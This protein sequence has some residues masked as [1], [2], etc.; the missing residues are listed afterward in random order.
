MII[1]FASVNDAPEILSIYRPYVLNTPVTFEIDAPSENEMARR[2]VSIGKTYP[3]LV[4]SNGRDIVGYAYAT[5]FRDRAAFDHVCESSIY[6]KDEYKGTGLA[7]ELYES[8]FDILTKQSVN[9][10]YAMI[11]TPNDASIRFHEKMGFVHMCVF[12][13]CGYK[14]GAWHDVACLQ[15]VIC[16]TFENDPPPFVPITRGR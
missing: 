1:R 2:I 16:R 10:V 9:I 4:A 12:E 8:L 5:R 15:N 13:N 14:L 3:Y 11:T 6:I 7:V